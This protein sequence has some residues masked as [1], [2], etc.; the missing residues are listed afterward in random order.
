MINPAK[1]VTKQVQKL[2]QKMTATF[3]I[4]VVSIW[5]ISVVWKS[6]E[7]SSN[8]AQNSWCVGRLLRN[9]RTSKFIK[10]GKGTVDL[11]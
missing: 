1:A 8:L 11:G 3:A 7:V 6:S 2:R 5:A 10:Y 9:C 4:L